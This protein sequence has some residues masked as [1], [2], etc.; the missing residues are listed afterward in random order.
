MAVTG[1]SELSIILLVLAIIAVG[2]MAPMTAPGSVQLAGAALVGGAA[3]F[4]LLA[5]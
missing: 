1:V 2:M 4:L 5:M 3:A